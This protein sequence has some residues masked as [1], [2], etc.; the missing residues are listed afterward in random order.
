MSTTE[1]SAAPAVG[2]AGDTV[3]RLYELIDHRDRVNKSNEPLE[4]E[5]DKVNLE[6]EKLRL[7]AEEISRKIDENRGGGAYWLALK[8]EIGFICT[9]L[10]RMPPRP[11]AQAPATK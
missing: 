2:K 1:K 5:L 9:G 6:A 11:E 3:A 7:K 4:A 8:K 10:G